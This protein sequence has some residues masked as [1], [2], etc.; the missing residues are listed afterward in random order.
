MTSRW[1]VMTNIMAVL[2][3]GAWRADLHAGLD[4]VA[5]RWVL[6][7]AAAVFGGIASAIGYAAFRHAPADYPDFVIGYAALEYFGKAGDYAML[8]GFIIGFVTAFIGLAFMM[9]RLHLYGGATAVEDSTARFLIAVIPLLAWASTFL[10]PY[11]PS[12]R[13]FWASAFLVVATSVGLVLVLARPA[14]MFN[15]GGSIRIP[16]DGMTLLPVAALLSVFGV[17]MIGNRIGVMYGPLWFTDVIKFQG[18]ALAA[19]LVA[20]LAVTGLVL[21]LRNR[22]RLIAVL[23][24][25][26][27]FSQALLPALFLVVLPGPVGSLADGYEYF[28]PIP[29]GVWVFLG[30]LTLFSWADLVRLWR[31]KDTS[32]SSAVSIFSLVAVVAFCRTPNLAV[33]SAPFDDYH[34]GEDFVPWWAWIKHGMIPLWDFTPPRGLINYKS[35]LLAALFTE[36]TAAGM[37]ATQSYLFVVILLA[38]FP[39]LALVIGKW[40]AFFVLCFATLDFRLGDIDALMTAGLALLV[41]A[42]NKYSHVAWLVIWLVIGTLAVLIAPGQGGLLV[43]ATMPGGLWRLYGAVRQERPRLWRIGA[44]TIVV[45]AI[46]ALT[47]PLGLMVAGAVRYGIGQSAVNGIANGMAWIDGFGTV[48]NM[49][50]WMVEILRFSWLGVGALAMILTIW[51]WV[52]PRRPNYGQVMFAGTAIAIMC[53]LYIVRA[54]VR[55]DHGF[56]GR[57]GWASVWALALLLPMLLVLFFHGRRHLSFLMIPVMGASAMAGNFGF[58]GIDWGLIRPFIVQTRPTAAE[59]VDGP[60]LGLPNLGIASMEKSRVDRLVEVKHEL[61]RLLDADETFLDMTNNGAQYYYYDRPPP[62]DLSAFYNMITPAQQRRAVE[63]LRR[64][65][66]SVALIGADN[67]FLDGLYPSLRA[68]LLYRHLVLNYVP[69]TIGR[70]DYMLSPDRL[71]RAGFD[72]RDPATPDEQALQILDRNF[73][74]TVLDRLADSLGRSIDT[75]DDRLKEVV[76]LDP[77]RVSEMRDIQRDPTGVYTVTG[78]K[79]TITFDLASHGLRGR[80]AGVLRF[81]F[82]CRNTRA[83]PMFEVSWTTRGMEPAQ[84]MTF[85]GRKGTMV[86]PLDAAPRWLLSPKIGT[87]SIAMTHSNGCTA[88]TLTD[89]ALEQRIGIEETDAGDTPTKGRP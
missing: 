57:P 89:V 11:S 83:K 8:L 63:G 39:C 44:I 55:L 52:G 58:N 10:F 43:A 30:T 85:A 18:A 80:D 34:A 40:R 21:S 88:F 38:V 22:D 87:F 12:V 32:L 53:T 20:G 47:T 26:L 33:P 73:L 72:V 42:W 49:H 65:R 17:G 15:A 35:G 13:F 86:L 23:R 79:P 3:A 51:T 28:R 54:A 24:A 76:R 68:T 4:I 27:I 46:L 81:D 77:D 5:R 31:R 61:D 29:V 16:V 14:L 60:A 48:A 2:R 7:L 74:P 6:W 1:P 71:P 84:P 37:V 69:V 19:A 50:P 64:H 36:P 75:L 25:L 67:V 62:A 45:L 56:I 59:T 9:R 70:Y 82:Q 78:T 66:V 41:F